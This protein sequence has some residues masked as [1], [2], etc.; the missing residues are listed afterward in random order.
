M[1]GTE[2]ED[3]IS[4]ELVTSNSLVGYRQMAENIALRYGVIVAKERV[5]CMLK[6][7]D[8]EGVSD[9]SKNVIKRRVYETLGPNDVYHIDGNDKLKK[10]GLCIH[11]CV[12]GFSRKLLWLKVATTNNDP[13]VIANYYLEHIKTYKIVPNLIRVDRGTENVFCDDLQV[14]FTGVADSVQYATSTRN[15]RIE[16]FW[17]RL[18]KF[19]LVWWISLFKGMER[20]GLYKSYLDTHVE[21]LIYIFLP[22]IQRELNEFSCI[23][24]TRHVRQ[25]ASTP[26]GKP[27]ILFTMPE[28]VGFN[29][30]GFKVDDS[31]VN[32]AEQVIGITHCPVWKNKDLYELLECY[33][34][35]H[36]I[37]RS[38][39]VEDGIDLYAKLLSFLQNDG[40]EI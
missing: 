18:K 8:P 26:G 39:C 11:G 15:Q 30:Q 32:I 20:N 36:G 3:M 10:W 31:D 33:V 24:N 9:R 17:S 19:R 14:F 21:V 4:N 1:T 29:K 35:I 5:R 37:H 25:S 40:F 16:A 38:V 34:N 23:W 2:L 28:T 6:R 12:D 22:I 27:D 7:L 13:L